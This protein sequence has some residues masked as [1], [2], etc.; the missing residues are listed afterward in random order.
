[1]YKPYLNPQLRIFRTFILNPRP[2]RVSS[3]MRPQPQPQLGRK[4]YSSYLPNQWSQ[5]GAQG[6][7]RTFSMQIIYSALK[8]FLNFVGA[9]L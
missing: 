6:G 2:A 5:R 7:K 3:R 9:P 1:M 4:F 8:T